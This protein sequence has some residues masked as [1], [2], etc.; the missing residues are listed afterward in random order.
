TAYNTWAQRDKRAIEETTSAKGVS[1]TVISANSAYGVMD[2][3]LREP[4]N[5]KKRRVCYS[6]DIKTASYSS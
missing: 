2:V 5:V 6:A 3:S 4:G 1:H